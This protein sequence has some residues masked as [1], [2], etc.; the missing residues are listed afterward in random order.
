MKP[1]EAYVWCLVEVCAFLGLYTWLGWA[2][3]A[4]WAI[5]NW[6]VGSV[7]FVLGDEE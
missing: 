2:G 3:V 1:A 4:T 6:I 5:V 7:L